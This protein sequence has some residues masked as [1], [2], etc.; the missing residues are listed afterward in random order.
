MSKKEPAFLKV[1]HG[2]KQ[3]KLEQSYQT[4]GQSNYNNPII[5]IDR[6]RNN[7][8]ET[9]QPRTK[10]NMYDNENVNSNIQN[11]DGYNQQEKRS[12]KP[13]EP[14]NN[15]NMNY[16]NQN[17]PYKQQSNNYH[18][19]PNQEYMDN[20]NTDSMYNQQY[21]NNNDEQDQYDMM[22]SLPK[23]NKSN[24]MKHQQQY[25]SNRNDYIDPQEFM[26]LKERNAYLET[27]LQNKMEM[28]NAY[29]NQT[30]QLD[31][32]MKRISDLEMILANKEK[33]LQAATD[34]IAQFQTEINDLTTKYKSQGNELLMALSKNKELELEIEELKDQEQKY[35][36]ERVNY[37]ENYDNNAYT[38]QRY[39]DNEDFSQPAPNNNYPSQY[40]D[41]GN[42]RFQD[43]YDEKYNLNK[44]NTQYNNE[45]NY[46]EQN[47]NNYSSYHENQPFSSTQNNLTN[48]N[49]KFNLSNYSNSTNQNIYGHKP[50]EIHPAMKDNLFF[51]DDQP[52]RKDNYDIVA[53]SMRDDDLQSEYKDLV[54]EREEKE[55]RLSRAP[56]QGVSSNRARLMKAQLEDEIEDLIRK[57]NITKREMKQ[58]GLY[59]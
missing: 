23:Q 47:T 7:I 30:S 20:D 25:S 46:R 40:D 54:R 1:L 21:V 57:I 29:Q 3:R 53:R 33:M 12:R 36:N 10:R 28:K 6:Q 55:R 35:F 48:N 11:F 17:Q 16:M 58:R 41:R 14:I 56:E 18:Q 50:P 44:N 5:E 45:Y 59:C 26:M 27:Q 52:E 38:N 31:D 13:L 24:N 22:N 32:A 9:T 19:M 49:N 43:R 34:A 42:N 4:Q 15:N 39:Y 37:Q 2:R 8:R 51:G